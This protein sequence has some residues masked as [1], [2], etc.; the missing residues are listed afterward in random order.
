[1]VNLYNLCEVWFG[2]NIICGYQSYDGAVVTY[3]PP[4]SKVGGSNPRPYMG[5]LVV[6]F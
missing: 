1:M 4:T 2:V 6:A 5:E 3:L